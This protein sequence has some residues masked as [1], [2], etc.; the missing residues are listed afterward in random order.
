M[1]RRIDPMVLHLGQFFRFIFK[2]VAG[3]YDILI[4]LVKDFTT[5]NV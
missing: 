4:G 5:V 1:I 2:N 3:R